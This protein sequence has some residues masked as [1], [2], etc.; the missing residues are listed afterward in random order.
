MKNRFV[1]LLVLLCGM[2][3]QLRAQ[4]PDSLAMKVVPQVTYD[5]LKT[6]LEGIDGEGR[7]KIAESDVLKEILKREIIRD[8]SQQI[9]ISRIS[10]FFDNSQNARAG[11]VE[12]LE[13]FKELFPEIPAS[14]THENPYFKVSAGFCISNEEALILLNRLRKEFPK[15]FIVRER[16]SVEELKKLTK[17]ESESESEEDIEQ[18]SI[19]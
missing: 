12:T 9:A 1:L 15:A 2:T 7:I 10:I 18:S 19:D 4:A 8:G 5:S 14:M 17:P 16:V 6:A 13:K 11:A 3:L